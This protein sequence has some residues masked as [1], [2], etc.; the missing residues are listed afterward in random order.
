MVGGWRAVGGWVVRVEESA[1]YHV[2]EMGTR[3]KQGWRCRFTGRVGVVG[4]GW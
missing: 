2:G 1:M 4:R 3:G